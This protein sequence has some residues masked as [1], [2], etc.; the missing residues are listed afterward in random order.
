[1]R[2]R[3]QILEVCLRVIYAST[4]RE[5]PEALALVIK[6]ELAHSVLLSFCFAVPWAVGCYG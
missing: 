2:V 1:M 6:S 4:P 3:H 5:R